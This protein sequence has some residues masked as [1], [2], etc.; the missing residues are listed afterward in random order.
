MA[1]AVMTKVNCEAIASALVSRYNLTGKE[2]DL[3]NTAPRFLEN[4]AEFL[5]EQI[6]HNTPAH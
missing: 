5:R 1:P 3:V 4:L 6:E 2:G